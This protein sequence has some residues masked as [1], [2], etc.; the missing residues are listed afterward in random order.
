MAT[1]PKMFLIERDGAVITWKYYN[2]PQNL[3]N[4]GMGAEFGEL[5][6]DF[7]SDPELRVGIFASA[8]PGVFIQHYDVS[9]L[10]KR[11]T[12]LTKEKPTTPPPRRINFRQ[13]S[14]PIIAAINAP[15]AGGGLELCMSFDFRF[16]SRT[17]SMSQGEVNVG[18]LPGGG[19]T[20]RMPR[21]IGIGR[22]LELMLTGRPVYADEAERIGLIT[23]ACMPMLLMSDVMAFAKVLAERPPL[24]VHHIRKCVYEGMEMDIEDGLAMESELMAELMA[25]DEALERMSAYVATGQ[26][27][28]GQI[29]EEQKQE[30]ERRL[31][32]QQD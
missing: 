26:K 10:V 14:K 5:L 32:E 25:S 6:N 8:I 9:D 22:A 28:Q 31:K 19:G 23:R 7:Y 30:L 12:E 27:S 15:V 17:A 2:P 24:A 18:I 1:K 16:M 4:P 21:L 29:I 20:Q 11:G 13:E 3:L